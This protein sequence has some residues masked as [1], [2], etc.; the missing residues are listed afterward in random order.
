MPYYDYNGN[1]REYKHEKEER[2]EREKIAQRK[3]HVEH[4]KKFNSMPL[5]EWCQIEREICYKRDFKY[6]VRQALTEFNYWYQQHGAHWGPAYTLKTCKPFNRTWIT[7]GLKKAFG[8]ENGPGR[9][10]TY[11]EGDPDK[12]VGMDPVFHNLCR[13]QYDLINE[14]LINDEKK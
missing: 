3:R 6:W 7:R 14:A 12:M 9:L 4:G 13:V 2:K 8:G 5:K 11:L 1:L 10:I